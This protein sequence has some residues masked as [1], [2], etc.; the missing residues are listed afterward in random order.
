MCEGNWSAA[1][2]KPSVVQAFIQKEMGVGWGCKRLQKWPQATATGELNLVKAPGKD[3][4]LV[5]DSTICQVNPIVNYSLPEA[6]QLPTVSEV[7]ASFQ[8]SDPHSMWIGASLD[9]LAATNRSK[10]KCKTKAFSCLS[11][12]VTYTVT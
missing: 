6:V 10:C 12:Q 9:F 7:C 5:L 11:S 2:A 3:L 8:P 4:R 1:E